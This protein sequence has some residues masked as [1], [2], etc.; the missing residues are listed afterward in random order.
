M[1]RELALRNGRVIDHPG[2]HPVETADENDED[3]DQD[4]GEAER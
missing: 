1:A 2:A 4:G 3:T